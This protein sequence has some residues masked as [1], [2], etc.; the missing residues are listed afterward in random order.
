MNRRQFIQNTA[1]IA[2]TVALA[3]RLLAAEKEIPV[4]TPSVSLK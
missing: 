1:L 3:P 2:S 4:R